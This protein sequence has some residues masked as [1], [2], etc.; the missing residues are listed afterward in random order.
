MLPLLIA[1][2]VNVPLRVLREYE[3]SQIDFFRGVLHSSKREQ[4][5]SI[6]YLCPRRLEVKQIL[7]NGF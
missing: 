3:L 2:V 4:Q 6:L 1:S 7:I 5:V